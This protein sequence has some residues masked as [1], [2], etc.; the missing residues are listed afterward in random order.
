MRHSAALF[1]VIT[2]V[3]IASP[4]AAQSESAALRKS[5][6]VRY[7]TGTT[8]TKGEIATIIRR[9]CLAFVPSDRDRQD[10]RGLGADDEIFH[11]I[12]RCVSNGNRPVAE[13]SAPAP[14]ATAPTLT[15]INAY[16]S[17]T[18]GS[19]AY[20]NVDLARGGS[21]IGGQRLILTGATAVPGGAHADPVAV[22]DASGRATFTVPA[23]TH[24]G[25]YRLTVA[26]ADGSAL[27][28]ATAVVLNTLPA[29]P[30]LTTVIPPSILVTPGV[31][32]SRTLVAT[33]TDAFGNPVPRVGVQLRAFPARPG[34]PTA[35]VATTDSGVARFTVPLAPLRA[36]DSIVVAVNDRP[37][38][39]VHVAP[40]E[41]VT[42][43]LLDAERRAA[44]G[45]PGVEA[46]YDSVLSVDPANGRALIGRGYARAFAGRYDLAVRDFTAA[47]AGEDRV[48]ALTGIG[49]TAL[50]EGNDTL[51]SRSFGEA[52][53]LAPND[54]AAATG[55]AYTEVW[56]LDPRLSQHRPDVLAPMRPVAYPANAADQFRNGVATFAARNVA[57]AEQALTAAA[58]AAPSWPDVFYERA[59]VYQAE[60]RT[61]QARADFDKYLTLRPTAIDRGA[62]TAR[63][64]ALSR[65]PGSAFGHGVL[66]PGLGQFY[67]KQ[68]ALG[69]VVLGGT[70][71][72]IAWALTKSTTTEL[73]TFTDPFGR[74]D[75][76]TVTT[77][78]R[79]NL[80][81]GIAVA[82]AVWLAGAIGAAIHAGGAR[83]DPYPP[84]SPQP[85]RKTAWLPRLVPVIRT[86]GPEPAFGAALSFRLR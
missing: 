18:S 67:T 33:V 2:A 27:D 5:D 55:R 29:P 32:G 39:S 59:L 34:I 75:T 23:G 13:R 28:G 83:G 20:V 77:T 54:P 4:L 44:E 72:G 43:L 36:G 22:T 76:F 70:A 74:V 78:R 35:V 24:A 84:A 42:A 38:A 58:A 52:H 8:Y 81:A 80:A 10:L 61:D 47:E 16:A 40:A 53:R 63:I 64:D 12:D 48:G 14:A 65:S 45:R 19:V 69:V 50:R 86:D 17:A 57:A 71:G 73:K 79:K 49:W 7:L 62:V 68:P 60:D 25:T 30:A 85:E 3:A 82:G 6:L 21:P 1:A 11:A 66:F 41:Q 51:A 9:S 31:S 56:R 37:A 46:A 15:V 26:A